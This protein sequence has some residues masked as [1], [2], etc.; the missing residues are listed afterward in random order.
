MGSG[1]PH[2]TING[3]PKGMIAQQATK[4]LY[5]LPKTLNK[6]WEEKNKKCAL[7]MNKDA[8]EKTG[9][10]IEEMDKVMDKMWNAQRVEI[11]FRELAAGLEQP[12]LG[13]SPKPT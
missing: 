11:L 4:D 12:I 3:K 5:K 2:R 1:L 7:Y 8:N 13:P 10:A 6:L 9:K